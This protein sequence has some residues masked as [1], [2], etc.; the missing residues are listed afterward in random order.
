MPVW[1]CINI[2]RICSLVTDNFTT[3]LQPQMTFR[4]VSGENS[5]H[6]CLKLKS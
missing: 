3:D 1:N 4:F 2:S 5:Y 6:I